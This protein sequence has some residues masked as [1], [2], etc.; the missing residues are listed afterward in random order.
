MS[1][2]TKSFIFYPLPEYLAVSTDR[3]SFIELSKDDVNPCL[4]PSS[5]ICPIL[6]AINRKRSRKACSVAV[7]MKD[8]DRV[9]EGF[10]SASPQPVTITCPPQSG[11]QASYSLSLST[12]GI[13]THPYIPKGEWNIYGATVITACTKLL[14]C[15]TIPA[16]YRPSIQ[17][18]PHV[19][20]T[21]EE[22]F[23]TRTPPLHFPTGF[24]RL[25]VTIGNTK[26]T[27]DVLVIYIG[28]APDPGEIEKIANY[29]VP[30]SAEEFRSF[31]GLAGYYRPFISNFG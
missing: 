29:K 10:S 15:P 18:I 3:Q 25:A 13:F 1:N 31:L 9:Q 6:R 14:T 26:V 17:C 24:A 20:G 7:F 16:T 11:K 27:G 12:L 23:S 28:I 30:S 5:A 22:R 21:I 8:N 2:T 19:R 4:T